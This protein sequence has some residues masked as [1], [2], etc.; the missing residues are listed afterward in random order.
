MQDQGAVE[1]DMQ[2]DGVRLRVIA[3]LQRGAEMALQSGCYLIGAGEDCDVVLTDDFV[4]DAHLAI[5][6]VDGALKLEA[7]D[8]AVAV[9][10]KLLRPGEEMVAATPLAISL[11]QTGLGVGDLETD[12][13]ALP[14]PD[15]AAVIAAAEDAAPEE[16]QSVAEEAADE[17]EAASD[18]LFPDTQ[19][20]DATQQQSEDPIDGNADDENA[21]RADVDAQEA[22][23]EHS[24]VSD[25]G[26]LARFK[27]QKHAVAIAG[28]LGAAVIAT[29]AFLAH[30]AADQNNNKALAQKETTVKEKNHD[31]V[32]VLLNEAG[33]VEVELARDGSGVYR[34]SGY[35]ADEEA[36]MSMHSTL[37]KKQVSFHDHVRQVDDIM[38]SVQFSLDHYKWPSVGFNQHLV[39]N[40]IGGGVFAIDGYLG[41]EVDRTDLNRQIMAD[42]PGV[43]RLDFKRARLADWRTELEDELERA[44]L[45]PW[46]TTE[47]VEGAI[48]VSG[49]VTPKEAEAWRKVG[50]AFVNESRGWPKLKIAVRAAGRHMLGATARATPAVMA[51]PAVAPRAA[52]P[53]DVNII[54]VIMPSNGP[55]R[56]LLDNGSSRA[57]GEA[58]YDGAVLQSISL[59]K[60]IIRK[61][62]KGLEFR[63]GEK[64]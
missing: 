28:A 27:E 59:N 23:A 18:E 48:H 37:Q 25:L 21:D 51:A 61:G 41:P 2:S 5:E 55:G 49:E 43:M 46:I 39:L 50:Q 64:G 20:Q 6:P 29:T 1:V 52:S 42:A 57:E 14:L 12:W 56:V 33:L 22:S 8:G 60:V 3:G 13:S 7:R 31:N 40:Y 32:R 38:R 44:G 9:G 63:V 58:L 36:R 34:L 15:L 62:D 17:N 16:D 54:G 4:A 30:G 24:A 47:L 45:K 53:S 19:A 10:D 26:L 11:G 35:V